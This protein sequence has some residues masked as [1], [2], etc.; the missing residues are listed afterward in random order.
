MISTVFILSY[1]FSDIDTDRTVFSFEE[2]PL[3][4]SLHDFVFTEKVRLAFKVQL[5]E[6]NTGTVIC[7]FYAVQSPLVH[8]LPQSAHFRIIL[9]PCDKH[10]FSLFIRFRM[11]F[12]IFIKFDI[13]LTYKVIAFHMECFRCFTFRFMEK[14]IGNHRFADMHTAVVDNVYLVY[15]STR[16][17]E[18]AAYTFTE[19]IV[20]EMTKMQRLVCVRTREFDH[21][22]AAG[23]RFFAAVIKRAVFCALFCNTRKNGR[24]CT[25]FIKAAV[26]IRSYGEKLSE[27]RNIDSG[28]CP[29]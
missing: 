8:K 16:L 21:D 28:N 14:F 24:S 6:R 26:Y 4:E 3:V 7:L 27:R 12:L 22:A 25:C 1:S 18:N 19:C 11:F 13:T 29:L 23:E 17:L 15:F 9:F 5:V 2:N 20:A 10:V